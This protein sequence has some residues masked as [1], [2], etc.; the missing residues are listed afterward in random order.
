LK[1]ALV[2]IHQRCRSDADVILELPGI[3]NLARMVG[4]NVQP[5][6]DEAMQC[7]AFKL[8]FESTITDR[9]S[10]DRGAVVLVNTALAVITLETRRDVDGLFF[11]SGEGTIDFTELSATGFDPSCS[12]THSSGPTPF[13]AGI[14]WKNFLRASVHASILLKYDPGLP[15]SHIFVTCGT[16]SEPDNFDD[17]WQ[18]NFY[19]FHLKYFADAYLFRQGGFTLTGGQDPWATVEVPNSKGGT[20]EKTTFTLTHTPR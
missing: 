19:A 8:R 14:S 9:H 1:K 20:S 16:G 10:G 11:T 15:E 7:L 5:E 18:T 12:V 4:A 3:A 2:N 17:L 13:R 6:I